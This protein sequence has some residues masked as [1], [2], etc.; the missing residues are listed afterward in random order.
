MAPESQ[1][2][3]LVAPAT[4]NE[5]LQP[6]ID[7]ETGG[8]SYAYVEACEILP[9]FAD[10][11]RHKNCQILK[12]QP[13]EVLCYV[14]IHGQ[15]VPELRTQT[16]DK[17]PID[18]MQKRVEEELMDVTRQGAGVL[19]RAGD[20][21]WLMTEYRPQPKRGRA[22]FSNVITT[23]GAK[24]DTYG[25]AFDTQE[26]SG[27][28]ER[29]IGYAR[30]SIL[31]ALGD[32]NANHE[33]ALQTLVPGTRE[34]DPSFSIKPEELNHKPLN[35]EG[36]ATDN[37]TIGFYDPTQ[38]MW[39]V[40]TVPFGKLD[41]SPYDARNHY[42]NGF[43]TGIIAQE[44]HG[45]M[46]IFRL[47]EH[48]KRAVRDAKKTQVPNV[49]EEM[50]YEM[51]RAQLTADRRWIPG[52]HANID[53]PES[54]EKGVGNRYYYRM[55]A[56]PTHLGPRIAKPEKPANFMMGAIGTVVGPYKGRDMLNIVLRGDRPV[57]GMFMET[58]QNGN[59][60]GPMADLLPY[61]GMGYDEGL[62]TQQ[63]DGD[64]AP[65]DRLLLEGSG[66]NYIIRKGNTIL[67]PPRNVLPGITA[68]SVIELVKSYGYEVEEGRSVHVQDILGAD[69]ILATGTAMSVRGVGNIDRDTGERDEK[70]SPIMER[71]F[72]GGQ[73]QMGTLAQRVSDDLKHIMRR[74]HSDPKFNDW[75]QKIA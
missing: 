47:D 27:E 45:E 2:H 43:F 30:V 1:H 69:E 8:L 14:N 4:I 36:I 22:A 49:T 65:E 48:V 10:R 50:L 39:T 67:M 37:Q 21:A 6:K 42:T 46:Y 71:I 18:L 3:T 54:G 68:K 9:E 70:G 72:S 53:N 56:T 35:F 74:E 40:Q 19:A 25:R 63:E 62:F 7:P 12:M 59:Y 17:Q 52:A 33:I 28:K 64:S 13:S 51:T 16:D 55:F 29:A 58:K 24:G 5:N 75:M 31:N 34:D 32:G 57:T 44:I 61:M 11:L 26:T 20:A 23:H 60:A 73:A 15:Y 41:I 38:K 66:C